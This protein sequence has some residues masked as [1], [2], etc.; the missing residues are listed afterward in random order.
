MPT[1]LRQ[2]T[3]CQSCQQRCQVTPLEVMAR[4]FNGRK[5][6]WQWWQ[7]TLCPPCQVATVHQL[8]RPRFVFPPSI[9]SPSAPVDL[10]EAELEAVMEEEHAKP[11]MK[12][13]GRGRALG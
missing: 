9:T 3:V 2:R 11:V 8:G 10:L 6:H 13:H 12:R 4:G 7:L 1:K 5:G